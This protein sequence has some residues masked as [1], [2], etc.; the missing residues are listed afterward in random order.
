[1]SIAEVDHQDIWQSATL[2]MA[3]VAADRVYAHG[4]LT[5]AVQA[6]LAYRLDAVV[7]DFEIEI[8]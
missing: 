7:R 3:C 1:V 8:Y 2:K 6:I 4:L 5:R